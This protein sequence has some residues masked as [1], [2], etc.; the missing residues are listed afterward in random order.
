MNAEHFDALMRSIDL[1]APRRAVLGVLGGGLAALLTRL[2]VDGVEAG[3]RKHKKHKKPGK[4]N[5]PGNKPGPT[6]SCP[7]GVKTC[8]TTCIPT[9]NC[10]APTDCGSGMACRDGECTCLAGLNRCGATCVSGDQ[11]CFDTSCPIDYVC[12]D[13]YCSCPH[14]NDIAC[15]NL[16]CDATSHD[17]CVSNGGAAICQS[18]GCP[19]TDWCTD[20]ILYLCGLGR[21]CATTIDSATVCTDFAD[22]LCI[23]CA[24]DAECATELGPDAVCIPNGLYCDEKCP[25]SLTSFC[26]ASPV[27]RSSRRRSKGATADALPRKRSVA[28]QPA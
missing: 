28:R 15:G 10:C 12:D 21:S 2:S 13:G 27:S 9:E 1:R 6:L 23:E 18:G 14:A 22:T 16:C 20:S 7:S 3:K 17:I 11:C 19:A 24:S 8:G 25:S 26:V 5:K 4:G